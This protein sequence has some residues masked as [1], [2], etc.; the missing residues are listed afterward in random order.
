[1][2]K[3]CWLLLVFPLLTGCNGGL[4]PQGHDIGTLELMQTM[5]LDLG[6]DGA[7]SKTLRVTVSGEA[8]QGA[9]SG[10]AETVFGALLEIQLQ[11]KKYL[12]YGHTTSCILGEAAAEAGMEELL[13]FLERDTEMRLNTRFY[14]AR[15][16]TAE[17]LIQGAASED[18][19]VSDRLDSLETDEQL[20]SASYPYTLLEFVTQL[21]RTGSGLVSALE[22]GENGV[23]SSG[24]ACISR[25]T[26]AGWLDED[27]SQG[28]NLLTGHL[29][30]GN[31]S[32]TLSDGSVVSLRLSAARCEWDTT[33]QG[34]TL[35][36]LTATAYVTASLE[37]LR[38]DAD[39]SDPAVW[40]ELDRLL[41]EKLSEKANA[42]LTQS[43]AWNADF[44]QLVDRAALAAPARHRLIEKYWAE[45]FPTL[46]LCAR[47]EGAVT[48]T[49]N[50]TRSLKEASS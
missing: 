35:Q 4:L 44:L 10:E 39:L 5:G 40:Q 46:T 28:V 36:G 15:G 49:Y 29:K 42:V 21:E 37:E 32:G 3:L 2:K 24:Y 23:E 25:G 13:D 7:G 8:G 50:I 48:R 22:L 34:E 12:T 45:W 33:F 30:S 11:S 16:C 47:V 27:I 6:Q 38:G 9:L 20:T 18:I 26:L 19:S 1:M 14:V 31:I 17:E 41:S 43:Q